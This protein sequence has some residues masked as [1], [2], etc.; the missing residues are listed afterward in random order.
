MACR[1]LSLQIF[2]K[3][4]SQILQSSPDPSLSTCCNL[5]LIALVSYILSF[6]LN[7]A[8][9]VHVDD[10]LNKV[11]ESFEF[12]DAQIISYELK[13]LTT[14]N[15]EIFPL[16]TQ[17]AFCRL[18]LRYSQADLSGINTDTVLS[19]V[20]M[21]IQYCSMDTF[22]LLYTSS[23][24]AIAAIIY[25]CS[26]YQV[27]CNSW[28][29]SIPD[30]CFNP[31]SK[32]LSEDFKS[33]LDVNTC[34]D[35]ITA[36]YASLHKP[37]PPSSS[38]PSIKRKSEQSPTHIAVCSES[39]TITNFKSVDTDATSTEDETTLLDLLSD[40]DTLSIES[41]SKRRRYEVDDSWEFTGDEEWFTNF[42][43]LLTTANWNRAYAVF[44]WR[45]VY[46]KCVFNAVY[47]V[48]YPTACTSY[49]LV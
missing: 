13:I 42:Q 21:T 38:S 27:D 3:Y 28:L 6:K 25:S 24:I 22:F 19:Y 29:Y 5:K 12:T 2:D 10:F 30:K 32:W 34:L 47:T 45:S 43:G 31:G 18:L 36:M 17:S 15:F 7:T 11:S 40:D 4:L 26:M 49:R 39:F 23:T 8:Y 16:C 46:I 41:D 33:S 35:R 14:I 1:D 9:M 44:W 48:Y 20:D 37:S